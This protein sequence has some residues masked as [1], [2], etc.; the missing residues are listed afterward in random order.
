LGNPRFQTFQ[1]TIV[2]KPNSTCPAGT[3]T[4]SG[5][6]V[7]GPSGVNADFIRRIILLAFNLKSGTRIYLGAG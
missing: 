1:A 7:S 5:T 3:D 2:P 4:E 6:Q